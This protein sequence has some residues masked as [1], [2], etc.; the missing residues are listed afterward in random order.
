MASIFHGWNVISSKKK[1]LKKGEIEKEEIERD[2]K[3][4]SISSFFFV[5]RK[6][7][8]V[9]QFLPEIFAQKSFTL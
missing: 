6:K 3:K 8:K 7:G 2:E 1:R 4:S 5:K 9:D